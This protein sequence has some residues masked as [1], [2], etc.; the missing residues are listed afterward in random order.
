MELRVQITLI[1]MMMVNE[2]ELLNDPNIDISKFRLHD[3]H[4]VKFYHDKSI[5]IL[6][7]NSRDIRSK[8]NFIDY[9]LRNLNSSINIIIAVETFLKD[10]DPEFI[11]PNF[12][13][14]YANRKNRKGGGVAIFIR[15][16]LNYDSSKFQ[17]YGDDYH[18]F[19]SII[20][21]TR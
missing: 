21:N 16:D 17:Y 20:L 13:G 7:F 11:I 19:V 4:D 12:R 6:Y 5:K 8:A 10:T 1:I 2:F 9:T 3:F 15:D 14:F 18:N